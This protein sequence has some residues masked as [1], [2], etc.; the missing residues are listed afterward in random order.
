MRH[1][2]NTFVHRFKLRTVNRLLLATLLMLGGCGSSGGSSG[3][4]ANGRATATPILTQAPGNT[5]TQLSWSVAGAFPHARDAFTEGLL[6]DNGALY[7]S[8]GI[9]GQSTLRKVDLQSGAVLQNVKLPNNIFG[10]GL[11][12]A[13]NKLYQLTW[14]T[15]VGYV[16]DFPTFKKLSNFSYSNEGWGLT[17]DGTSLI[18][19]DGTATITFRDPATFK[20]TRRITVTRNGTALKNI[21]ELEWIDGKIWANVWQTDNIVVIN[22]QTGVIESQLDMTGLLGAADRNGTE[23]VL[24]GIAYDAT[25]KRIFVTGKYWPK[26]YWIRVDAPT[27]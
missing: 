22:P 8:T 9:E 17:F 11:A 13:N 24:N 3:S 2:T 15:K 27:V 19:S 14:Q 18:Q 25:N 4:G 6:W 12:L 5:V 7:E 10:E 1:S 26:L 16:Y 20:A 23:D 21:N